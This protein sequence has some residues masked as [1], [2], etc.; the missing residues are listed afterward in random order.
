[1]TRI[2]L[3]LS[4]DRHGVFYFRARIPTRLRQHFNNKAETKRTLKTD[5]R[6]E[7]VKLARAYRVELDTEMAELENPDDDTLRIN[8][9]TIADFKASNGV[10]AKEIKID[11]DGDAQKE[12]Q[13]LQALTGTSET[14]NTAL[15][16]L[17]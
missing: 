9:I 8:L 5:S 4:Q 6:R 2:P 11:F 7:A 3:Y 12:M 1:M 17:W 13:A 15:S 14:T 10:E 16:S